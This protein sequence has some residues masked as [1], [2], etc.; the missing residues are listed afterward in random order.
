MTDDELDALFADAAE[1][2]EAQRQRLVAT[3]GVDDA[4]R[5]DADLAS[6]DIRFV[7]AAGLGLRGSVALLGTL[8]DG[9][10]KWGWANESLP[11]AVRSGSCFMQELAERTGLSIFAEV[12]WRCT[13]EQAQGIAELA[14]FAVEGD[15][16]Y[17]MHS[18]GVDIYCVVVSL[19]EEPAEGT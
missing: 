5:W 12:A 6:G 10:W 18:R 13:D 8:K 2:C 7:T 11:E 16:P 15:C 19:A 3:W 14:C 17:R 1:Y 9:I 4:G